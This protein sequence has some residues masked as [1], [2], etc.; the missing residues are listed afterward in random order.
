M[1]SASDSRTITRR[2]RRD[3]RGLDQRRPTAARRSGAGRRAQ[4]RRGGLDAQQLGGR[5]LDDR[6]AVAD[7]RG[8]RDLIAQVQV[9]LAV[10]DEVQQQGADVA[11]VE[12]ARAGGHRGRQVGGRD[13][14]H[15][16]VGH[17]GL[18]G[19]RQLD[20][21]AECA[22]GHVHDDRAGLHE[23][24]GIRGHEDRRP[25]AGDL[26]RGDDHVHATDVAVELLLLGGTLLRGQL[27]G[28]AARARRVGDRLELQ[29]LGAQRLGLLP[30]L[31]ADVVCLHLRAEPAGRGDG[32]EAGH[33]D[34]Q[35]EHV[36]GLGRA[37]GSGQQREV[38][39]VRLG[40]DDDG[41]V[42]ADVGLRRQRVH[43]LGARQRAR[44]RIE[45]DGRDARVRERLC[46]LRIDERLEQPDDRLA[47]AQLADLGS[48]RLL[49]PQHDIGLAVQLGRRDDAWRRRPRT[50][51]R[52]TRS[53]RPHPARRAR[54]RPP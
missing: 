35:D 41:L 17:D 11:G 22:G 5:R 4:A 1:T 33:A 31:G 9:Q 49:D 10:L 15:A 54:R 32:L 48:R 30:G 36:G 23:L 53:L 7:D 34:A 37:G 20:V 50:P 25:S 6:A 40:G 52:G 27:A 29:E 45:A 21:A 2:R 44:Q 8:A 46:R 24:D 18:V 26:G 28:V 51:S 19:L 13:D 3:D 14:G 12:R 16:V 38:A 42:A 39:A 43:G 47:A